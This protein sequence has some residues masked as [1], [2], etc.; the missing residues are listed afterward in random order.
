MDMQQLADATIIEML[1]EDT[2]V[3]HR[4]ISEVTGIPESTVR[5]RVQKV[6]ASGRVVPSVLVHPS[7]EARRLIFM[8]RIVLV[9]GAGPADLME[10]P[11]LNI[12][13]WAAVAASSQQVFIQLAAV[14]LEDMAATIAEVR[15]LP[16]VGVVTT[17]LVSRVYVGANWQRHDLPEEQ[18]AR[19]PTR[20]LDDLDRLLV[21]T[22]RS[23][24]RASYTDLAQVVGLTVAATRRRV[25]RL[26]EDG[27]IRFATRVVDGSLAS[28]EASVDVLL[29][30]ANVEAFISDVC[31]MREI[32]YVIEQTGDYNVSCYAVAE[33]GAE[34][35]AAVDRIS[36]DP[37]VIAS[38]TDP[39]LIL[40]DLVSWSSVTSGTLASGTNH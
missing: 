19:T 26:S 10:H 7:I 6:I 9:D 27:L 15:T 1:V 3:T 20:S 40:Q 25:L 31:E 14:D 12:S 29:G 24:G 17:S 37:R 33:S 28:E 23:D 2:R 8:M 38:R 36:R 4:K 30:A 34:L 39:F 18:W 22:L 13:P 32:R 11:Q 5:S 35:L 21:D 16:E